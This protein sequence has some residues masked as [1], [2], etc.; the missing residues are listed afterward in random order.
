MS[1]K[2]TNV[3][4][5]R[6]LIGPTMPVGESHTDGKRFENL[7][8]M[9]ELIDKLLFDIATVANCKDRQEASMSRAGKYAHAFLVDVGE[10]APVDGQEAHNE[11]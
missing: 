1:E 3:D 2:M 8:E 11:G 6:K 10:S 7:Q 4:V 5:V 9:T